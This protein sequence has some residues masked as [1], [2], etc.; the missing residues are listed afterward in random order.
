MG[1]PMVELLTN[2]KDQM[3]D[4]ISLFK[5]GEEGKQEE[6]NA[7]LV[8]LLEKV[9]EMNKLSERTEGVVLALEGPKKDQEE[10][11]SEE[12]GQGE[13]MP[14]SEP[15]KIIW[16]WNIQI[17]PDPAIAITTPGALEAIKEPILKPCPGNTSPEDWVQV[18]EE[19]RTMGS[20][21]IC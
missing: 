19:S 13:Q 6:Y 21:I 9:E 5:A 7:S 18:Q 17:L 11:Q 20:C 12:Q 1:S 10:E 14:E 16:S 15:T 2:I 3:E 4:L 8:N